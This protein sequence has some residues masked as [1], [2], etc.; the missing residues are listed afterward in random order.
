M[1]TRTFPF[2]FLC[3]VLSDCALDW[4]RGVWIFVVT[5]VVSSLLARPPVLPVAFWAADDI[6]GGL[7]VPGAFQRKVT[8]AVT[9]Q[10]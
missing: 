6:V 7:Q 9:R 2:P 1:L 3:P 8:V 4:G 10:Q 5:V